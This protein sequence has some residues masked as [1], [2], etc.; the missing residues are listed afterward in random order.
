MR[1]VACSAVG[2]FLLLG[3]VVAQQK[4]AGGGEEAA[5]RAIEQKW[6]DAALKGDVATLGAILADTFVSTSAD[7]H[8]QSKAEM[9]GQIKSGEVKYESSKVDEVKVTVYGSAAILMGRWSGKVVE[10]GTPVESTERFT[11]TFIKQNG[12][13]RCVAS[14]SSPIH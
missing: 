3:A 4:K 13:W 12:Q 1:T 10:K 6:E 2:L 5:L 9:L 11:D 7:G 8:I 14:H